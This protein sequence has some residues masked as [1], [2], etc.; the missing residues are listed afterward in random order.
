MM[1]IVTP[2]EAAEAQGDGFSASRAP[3]HIP[4]LTLTG[5]YHTTLVG[6]LLKHVLEQ[7]GLTV[8]LASREGR[9]V[10]DVREMEGDATG[11]NSI[12]AL[13]AD[14][15][16][17]LAVLET[18]PG[19]D[20]DE[21]LGYDCADVAVLLTLQT[22]PIYQAELAYHAWRVVERVRPGGT[23]IL[24]ADDG[25]LVRLMQMLPDEPRRDVVLFSVESNS[26][27]LRTHLKAGGRAYLVRQNWL[28][29][30]SGDKQLQLAPL[31]S[32]AAANLVLT[33]Q[34]PHIL[35][36]VAAS[37]AFLSPEQISSALSTFSQMT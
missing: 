9:Y 31:E 22:V 13:L 11:P 4:V 19:R 16:L 14:P 32:E 35:A 23:L 15:R 7:A 21:P 1:R 26:L 10:K 37:R 6:Y 24:N 17:D 20:F 8:G 30:A 5:A 3:A 18:R 29:E 25:Q 34:P 12:Q 28:V 36:A 2:S 27:V 33:L